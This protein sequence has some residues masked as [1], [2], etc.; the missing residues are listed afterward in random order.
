MTCGEYKTGD[1]IIFSTRHP[2]P[3]DEVSSPWQASSLEESMNI[4]IVQLSYEIRVFNIYSWTS[5]MMEFIMNEMQSVES[6]ANLTLEESMNILSC[7]PSIQWKILTIFLESSF[8]LFFLHRKKRRSLTW[9][10]WLPRIHDEIWSWLVP[11]EHV[12]LWNMVCQLHDNIFS[13][14]P[15]QLCVLFYCIVSRSLNWLL[16]CNWKSKIHRNTYSSGTDHNQI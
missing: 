10:W 1:R 12:F 8:S 2:P 7:T 16:S 5:P 4:L 13:R 9:P 3:H 6:M 14:K 15:I 11:D